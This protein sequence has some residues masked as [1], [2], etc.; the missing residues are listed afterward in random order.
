MQ[1]LVLT[2]SK[3]VE[4]YEITAWSGNSIGIFGLFLIDMT[5]RII[6]SFIQWAQNSNVNEGGTNGTRL[7]KQNDKISISSLFSDRKD[8]E[9]HYIITIANFI[10]ILNEYEILIK[11]KV[12]KITITESDDGTVTIKGE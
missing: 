5:L 11:T 7:K 9:P 4:V 2:F 6:P 1:E 12:P 10:R 3:R 8:K